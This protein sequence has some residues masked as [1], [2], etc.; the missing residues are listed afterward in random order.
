[1]NLINGDGIVQDN[2]E[3]LFP[4]PAND[5]LEPTVLEAEQE[6]LIEN[7]V[8]PGSEAD[9]LDEMDKLGDVEDPIDANWMSQSPPSASGVTTSSLGETTSIL[10]NEP[11]SENAIDRLSTRV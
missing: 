7:D 5:D 6:Y 2:S 11:I 9:F 1:M 10:F 8:E 4:T 3:F